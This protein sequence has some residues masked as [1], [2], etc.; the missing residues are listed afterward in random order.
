MDEPAALM[1]SI[2]TRALNISSYVISMESMELLVRTG[3][4]LTSV[5]V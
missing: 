1:G 4:A 2:C 3:I 5:M